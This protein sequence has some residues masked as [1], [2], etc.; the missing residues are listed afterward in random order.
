MKPAVRGKNR[1]RS[2]SAMLNKADN[3]VFSESPVY[4]TLCGELK[5]EQKHELIC[6]ISEILGPSPSNISMAEKIFD[7][8]R[9]DLAQYI[10]HHEYNSPR[11]VSADLLLWLETRVDPGK[12]ESV[13]EF[14]RKYMRRVCP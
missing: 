7:C 13:S 2:S 9:Y 11:G 5:E 8:F 14:F 3:V 12:A 10:L 1:C 6:R 4:E